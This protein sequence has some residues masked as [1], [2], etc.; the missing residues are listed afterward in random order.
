MFNMGCSASV[1]IQR[2]SSDHPSII[3][4]SFQEKTFG[5]VTIL[6]GDGSIITSGKIV[7]V[8]ERTQIFGRIRMNPALKIKSDEDGNTY[9]QKEWIA[10]YN[11][12]VK[13]ESV[14][15]SDPVTAKAYREKIQNE[16]DAAAAAAENTPRT[17]QTPQTPRLRQMP[18]TPIRKTV[19]GIPQPSPSEN[20]ENLAPLPFKLDLPSLPPMITHP[21]LI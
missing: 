10:K 16:K 13:R 5:K 6:N 18:I 2:H 7:P 19:F 8:G 9:E 15:A 3:Q 4:S 12:Q 17:P 14:Y 20:P 21:R 11:G 1:S